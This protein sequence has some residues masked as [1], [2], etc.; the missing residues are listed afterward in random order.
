MIRGVDLTAE[1]LVGAGAKSAGC[2]AAVAA[3]EASAQLSSSLSTALQRDTAV[4]EVDN[5]AA[6][7]GK[8]EVPS[9]LLK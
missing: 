8:T 7:N 6:P 3:P 9:P 2:L 5:P 4:L 1:K